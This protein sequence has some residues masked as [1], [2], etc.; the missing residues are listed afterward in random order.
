MKN[1]P[2]RKASRGNRGSG[3]PA[4]FALILLLLILYSVALDRTLGERQ[5]VLA[6][7]YENVALD[8]AESGIALAQA[9]LQASGTPAG[10]S[11]RVDTFR[12]LEG[13]L[14][15]KVEREPDQRWR[16]ISTGRLKDRFG[17]ALYTATVSV[18]GSL[19]SSGAAGIFQIEEF[20]EIPSR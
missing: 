7:Y 2:P 9:R 8:L 12:G 18:R 11:L 6:F 19:K 10:Q 16:I 3:L 14:E 20:R 17:R 15:V 1:L 13:S 5:H 4:V